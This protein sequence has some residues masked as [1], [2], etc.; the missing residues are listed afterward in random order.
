MEILKKVIHIL[1]LI[2]YVMIIVYLLVL[3]PVIIGFRPLVV[4]SGSMEPTYKTGSIMYYE[5]GNVDKIEKGDVI[6]FS[7]HT[8]SFVTHRVNDIENGKYVTKGDANSFVDPEKVELQSVK[9]KAINFSIPFLGYYIYFMNTHFGMIV[10]I[11]LILVSEFLLSNIRNDDKEE[12]D[13][14]EGGNNKYEK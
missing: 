13:A 4:L 7:S 14:L 3:S 6:V 10:V 9:G 8:S 1:S 2:V 12:K 11:I 5:I